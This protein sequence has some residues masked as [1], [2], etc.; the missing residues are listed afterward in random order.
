MPIPS[1]TRRCVSFV[2]LAATGFF[3]A[4]MSA[5]AAGAVSSGGEAAAVAAPLPSLPSA[6]P[7]PSLPALPG[8]GVVPF[9]ALPSTGEAG[10]GDPPPLTSI[11]TGGLPSATDAGTTGTTTSAASKAVETYNFV[12]REDAE[13][14]IV[15]DKLNNDDYQ[16]VKDRELSRIRNLGGAGAQQQ[17]GQ[18]GQAGGGGNIA[19]AEWDFYFE[20][21]ELYNE[22]VRTKILGATTNQDEIPEPTYRTYGGQ[23]AEVLSERTDLYLEFK[24]LALAADNKQSDQNTAFLERLTARE[25]RRNGFR[26]WVARQRRELSDWADLRARRIVNGTAWTEGAPVSR[27]DWYYGTRF[28]G[29]GAVTKVVDSQEFLVSAS[30]ERD[31]PRSAL[32]VLSTNLTPYDIIDPYGQ[33]KNP[34]TERLRGTFVKPPDPVAT[35]GTVELSI[36]NLIPPASE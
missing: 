1:Y 24:R 29:K 13:L 6:G 36:G 20:Q 16:K 7:D 3:L 4:P 14:G 17:Q 26:D 30:P 35:T 28:N 19:L 25:D 31:V 18:Q 15:R 2:L 32:N 10:A 22:Y 8:A 34:G 5:S 33:I 11:E 23:Q 21:L 12:F 9:G 27:D